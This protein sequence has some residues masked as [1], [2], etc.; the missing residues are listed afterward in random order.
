MKFI[1]YILFVG[2]FSVF[3][4]SAIVYTIWHNGDAHTQTD[5]ERDI[6]VFKHAVT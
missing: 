4:F 3:G 5:I 2:V 1:N 6:R